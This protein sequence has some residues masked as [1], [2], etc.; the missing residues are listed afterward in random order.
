MDLILWRH[1]EAR[2]ARDGEADA[3]RP[4]TS[5]GERQAA[6]MAAWLSRHLP[7]STRI[8]ASPTV[9]TR[10]TAEALAPKFRVVDELAP[11]RSVTE[12]LHA[13]RWP[14]TRGPVLVVGHQATLGMTAAYL[15]SGEAQHWSVRNGAIWWLRYRQRDHG[16]S[17][18]L[19][20]VLGPDGA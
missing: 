3:D 10:Q 9:R 14:D 13:A 2:E 15:L 19:Q 6:K 18:V 4:L 17:V 20:A 7:E 1:A 5:K 12:L 8:L 11:E 16:S